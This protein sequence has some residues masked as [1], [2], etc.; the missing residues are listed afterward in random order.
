MN[1]ESVFPQNIL[2]DEAIESI[3]GCKEFKVTECDDLVYINYRFCNKSTFPDP[4]TAPDEKTKRL[5][6]IRR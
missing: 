1:L 5:W 3:K 2:L 4:Q 6:A